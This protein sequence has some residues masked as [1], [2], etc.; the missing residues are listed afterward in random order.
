MYILDQ[1]AKIYLS[2]AIV[3]MNV[4]S[5]KIT[6]RDLYLLRRISRNSRR[7]EDQL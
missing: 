2:A 5:V 7:L 6:N 4:R 3:A 1:E